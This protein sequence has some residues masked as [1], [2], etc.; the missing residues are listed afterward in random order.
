[1]AIEK[2]NK[3]LRK[4]Q[5]ALNKSQS[6]FAQ[7]TNIRQPSLSEYIR[8]VTIPTVT[9]VEKIALTTGVSL[10]WLIQGDG[11]MFKEK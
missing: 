10:N 5:L 2:F 9:V 11:P 4:L 8:G 6:E 3:R 1:M 7:I